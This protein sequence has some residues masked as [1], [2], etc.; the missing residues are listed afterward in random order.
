[1]RFAA[2]DIGSNAIRFQVSS[3]IEDGSNTAFKKLE[4]IRFPLRLGHDVFSF[5][6]ISEEN[7]ARFMKLMKAFK[8]LLEL[9][10]VNHYLAYATSAMREAKNG[11]QIAE[12]VYDEF[13]IKIEIISGDK[14]AYII[15]KG[16]YSFIEADTY[17]H[18][19][20]GGGSTELN[21][22]KKNKR[23]NSKSFQIGSVRVLEHKD[24]E[25]QWKLMKE[26]L[27]KN[28]K[29]FNRD[30][31][32]IGTGGNISKVYELAQ[33][34]LG[35]SISLKKINAIKDEIVPL[36]LQERMNKYRLNA[37]RADVIV[38]AI[39]IYSFVMNTVKVGKIYVPHVGLKDGMINFLFD[40][41]QNKIN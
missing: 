28:M 17:L 23:I 8:L 21:F 1:M 25:N 19:D 31:V 22:Y 34:K 24:R 11:N 35:K 9:Y 4:Y 7:I 13:G 3:L 36:S 39:E 6:K 37:D 29:K 10:E 27:R 40:L 30:F 2:I 33:T 15:N 18:I 16:L 14:E 41:Q 12:T 20:V 26:W 38:P 5:R 32:V